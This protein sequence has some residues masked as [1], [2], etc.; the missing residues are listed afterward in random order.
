MNF[1]YDDRADVSAGVMFS[2]SDLLGCPVRVTVSPRNLKE[3]CCEITARD[4]SFAHK[5]TVADTANKVQEIVNELKAQLAV[6]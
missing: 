1:I 5:P 2:D 3:G 4:K 6:K